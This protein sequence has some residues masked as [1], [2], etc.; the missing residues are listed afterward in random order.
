MA[1]KKSIENNQGIPFEYWRVMPYVR[2][3]FAEKFARASIRVWLNQAARQ[4]DK[5]PAVLHDFVDPREFE[6]AL[7]LSG[8]A[9]TA[10]LATGDLRAAFYEQLKVL[11][12]FTDAE[13]IL[14]K[15][16]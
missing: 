11:D 4:A 3:D 16:S 10:A 6:D 13:D 7:S 2:V 1:L 8:D 9:F 5:Q 12:F 15:D 14:E